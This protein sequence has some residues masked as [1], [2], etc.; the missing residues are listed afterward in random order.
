[1]KKDWEEK[2]KT[3]KMIVKETFKLIEIESNGD[4]M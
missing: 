3:L 4:S 2:E 1:L